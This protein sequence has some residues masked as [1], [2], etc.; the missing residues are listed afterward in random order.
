MDEL[1]RLH[2]ISLSEAGP[3]FA[4]IAATVPGLSRHK[5]R[6]AITAGLVTVDGTLCLDP[7]QTADAG[8]TL[9]LDLRQGIPAKGAQRRDRTERPRSDRAFTILH[10]DDDLVV[11]DK[12][13]GILSAPIDANSHGHIPELLRAHW[14]ARGIESR[15]IGVVHRIDQETSGCLVLAKTREAQRIIQA[16]F[17]T[18]SAGRTYRCLVA[19]NP[20]Q[21]RDTL[22]GKIGRGPDG[23]RAVVEDRL[24]GKD[25]ITHFEVISRFIR[26]SELECRLETGRTHQIR[27]HLAAIGCPVL[28][29][30]VYGPQP[31]GRRRRSGPALPRAPR[32]MLH[33]HHIKLD[34]P[35]TG[36]RLEC[37]AP[38]PE[39]FAQLRGTLNQA[40][41][42]S[43][44][45]Q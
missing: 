4:A 18:H 19:G 25:A 12:A 36:L 15:F 10:E 27:V 41:P 20:R 31:R 8:A 43:P 17:T 24:P 33:A 3:L 5:A 21:D 6:L 14:K 2:D 13:S 38:L 35:R 44:E 9:V 28:G 34:H 30:P 42:P 29:D 1:Y 39:L 40:L 37:D 22:T 16:Q 26:G 45:A 23:R 7:Q 32:L 11:I